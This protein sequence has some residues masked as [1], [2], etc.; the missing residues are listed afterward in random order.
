MNVFVQLLSILLLVNEIA[1]FRILTHLNL[2]T[3]LKLKSE[4]N[5]KHVAVKLIILQRFQNRNDVKDK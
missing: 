2:L 1:L 3:R 4:I 5:S